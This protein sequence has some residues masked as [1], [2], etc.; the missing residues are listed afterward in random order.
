[1]ERIDL[2][3]H[4]NKSDGTFSPEQ[5]ADYAHSI[6]LKAIAVTDHDAVA[7]IGPAIEQAKKYELEIVPGIEISAEW[8]EGKIEMEIHMLGYFIEWQ[9]QNLHKRLKDLSA[10]RIERAEKIIEKLKQHRMSIDMEDVLEFAPSTESVGRL[11]IAQAML[12]QGC[13]LSINHAFDQYIGNNKSC[14]APKYQLSPE[15]A[16]QFIKEMGGIAVIAHP[17]LLDQSFA[18][19]LIHRLIAGGLDGIEIYYPEHRE[20]T[21]KYLEGIAGMNNLLATGG[22]DCHG[23]A[24][25][26]ILMGTLDIPYELLEKMK[27]RIMRKS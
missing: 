25:N 5:V 4:T 3:V 18:D 16:I 10:A 1:M 7:G 22:T 17:G 14:Y 26:H 24:K 2:H 8:T 9:N 23:L 27:Q 12:K 15:G 13:V 19:N 11:H 20:G 21:I 6:G